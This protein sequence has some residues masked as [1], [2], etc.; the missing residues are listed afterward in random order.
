[1]LADPARNRYVDLL[2]AVSILVVVLGHWLMAAPEVRPGGEL[3][4]GHVLSDIPWTQRLTWVFQVMPVFFMVGGYANASSLRS[5]R[6]SGGYAAW[7]HSRLRRLVGPVMVLLVFWGILAWGL[8]VAGLDPE[9]VRVGSQ[10]ALVPVWFLA[11]YIGV[12]AISPLTLWLWDRFGW[13]S[14]AGGVIATVG[15]DVLSLSLNE[16]WIGWW[17]YLFLWATVHQFGYAWR[18]RLLNQTRRTLTLAGIGLAALLVLT[19]LFGYPVSMVGVPGAE[20]NNTL[21]P[22]LPLLG[23]GVLQTGLLLSLEPLARRWLRRPRP[24]TATVLVNSMIMTVYLWHLTAMVL[25]LAILLG[26]GGFGLRIEAGSGAW[27]VTRPPW[28]AAMAAVTVPLVLLLS[29]FERPRRELAAPSAAGAISGVVL[30]CSGLGLLA[31][32]GVGDENGL[33]WLA[34]MLTFAGG[35]VAGVVRPERRPVEA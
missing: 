20:M 29:R 17:N 12:V 35:W 28:L 13:W 32:F 31:Y 21:P 2:R 18:D 1:V 30:V 8:L 15:V 19:E 25:I 24:W 7:L 14:I 6:R 26:L 3:L 27:W 9:L 34:L 10:T 5:S 33:N 4:A 22:R 23:L 16:P 11:V